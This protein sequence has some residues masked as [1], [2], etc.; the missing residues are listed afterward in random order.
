MCACCKK[1]VSSSPTVT[2]S[3]TPPSVPSPQ[4]VSVVGKHTLLNYLLVCPL[5]QM[6]GLHHY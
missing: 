2:A 3:C 5:M 1:A 6:M 4:P